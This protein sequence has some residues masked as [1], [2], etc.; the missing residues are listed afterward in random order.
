[1]DIYFQLKRRPGVLTQRYETVMADPVSAVGQIGDFIG[2]AVAE[3]ERRRIVDTIGI[4]R[5]RRELTSPDGDQRPGVKT[6]LLRLGK[7]VRPRKRLID[8][9]VPRR[10]LAK[11]SP[12]FYARSD[13]LIH[14]DHVAGENAGRVGKWRHYLTQA[15]AAR[16][17]RRYHRWFADAGYGEGTGT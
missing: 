2:V 4:E 17:E 3:R 16:L 7:R 6:R 11:I 10:W 9:G 14:I 5:I 13:S 8:L 12:L 15:Q 1:V